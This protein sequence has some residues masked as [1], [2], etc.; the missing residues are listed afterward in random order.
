MNKP[1]LT[2]AVLTYLFAA[3]GQTHHSTLNNHYKIMK[4]DDEWKQH[5]SDEEYRITRQ[6][7]TERAFSGAYNNNYEN[8]EYLCVCCGL[9]LFDSKAKFDSS[10][11][12]PSFYQG[13][14]KESLEEIIDNSHGMVR[15]EINCSRC[16]AH[17]GHLFEDGPEPTGLR[18]CMNSASLK[19]VKK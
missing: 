18:Y 5:L 15:T 14:A 19:F 9:Q 16:G 1:I 13:V 2:T 17:L 11:G 10:T 12:W 8:G 3:G 7:G 6:K 4:T